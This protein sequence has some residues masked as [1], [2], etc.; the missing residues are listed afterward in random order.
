MVSLARLIHAYSLISI[1][2]VL[3]AFKAN[4]KP[5][6]PAPQPPANPSAPSAG[7]TQGSS[8]EDDPADLFGPEFAAQLQVGME[9]LL[10]E[11]GQAPQDGEDPKEIAAMREAW[12]K[13]LLAGMDERG[14]ESIGDLSGVSGGAPPTAAN[15]TSSKNT[16][17][18]QPGPSTSST[19]NLNSSGDADFQKTIRQAMEKLKESDEALK[20]FPFMTPR[21]QKVERN[22]R[23]FDVRLRQPQ[24]TTRSPNF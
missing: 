23:S 3:D 18:S 2:D 1:A 21:E 8:L 7:P 20:V 24:V 5:K 6:R 19:S 22:T 15:P 9:E 16:T 11:L 12:E 10:K 13:M 4:E 14:T 17:R